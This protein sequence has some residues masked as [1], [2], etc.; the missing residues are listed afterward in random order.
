M[1]AAIV[2]RNAA[3]HGLRDAMLNTTIGPLS[4]SLYG[5]RSARG[6]ST[7]DTWN[8]TRICSPIISIFKKDMT[9]TT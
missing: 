3:A 6:N 4:P 9:S 8:A 1:I 5:Y 2:T 7:V